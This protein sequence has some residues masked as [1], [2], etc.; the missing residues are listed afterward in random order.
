MSNTTRP[1]AAFTLV[2]VSLILA[3]AGVVLAVAIPAFVRAMRVSKVAEAREEL[4][5][6]FEHAALYYATPQT[7]AGRKQLRCLPEAAGPTP[8]SPSADPRIVDFAAPD[9]PGSATWRAL[10]YAPQGPIRFRYTLLPSAAGCGRATALPHQPDAPLL[11]LRAEGDLDGDGTLSR[12]EATARDRG[13]ELVLDEL[14]SV[15]N[16]VE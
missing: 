6:I 12:F 5:R 11:T 10:D 9:T 4:N 7:V 16:R 1:T 15:T 2:E 3:V 14:L 13:G 8:E